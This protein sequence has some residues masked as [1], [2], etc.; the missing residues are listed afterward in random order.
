MIPHLTL[1]LGGASSGKTARAEAL[2]RALSPAP[3][4]LAT[5]QAFDAEMAAKIAAHRA[6]R[7]PGW[8]TV[9]APHDPAAALASVPPGA[10]VLLD[11]LTM[12]L[13]NRIF[14]GADPL[15]ELPALL[16]ALADCPAPVVVVSNEVGQG[17]VPENAL[18]RRF[19]TVQGEANQ[20]LA[21]EA[22]LVVAVMAG[23]PLAL[24]GT[25]PGGLAW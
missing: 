10:A 19:R 9:E 1:V 16:A 8:Q 22:D 18:A 21:A 3:V 13:G 24:K 17:I 11:C 4:Y 20:R 7:G 14:A 6:A 5:G 2:T 25:L 12:W 23:L 15:A